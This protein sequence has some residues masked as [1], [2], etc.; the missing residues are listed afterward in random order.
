MKRVH[1]LILLAAMTLLALLLLRGSEKSTAAAAAADAPCIAIT[2]DDGPS[3]QTTAALLDG[4]K[5]RGAHTTFFLIGE[6]VAGNETL[7]R[8]MISEGHQVGSHSFTHARLDSANATVLAEIAQTEDTLRAVLGGSGYWLRPPWGFCSE[9]LKQSVSV[10]L[11]FWSLDTMDWSV[12]NADIVAQTIIDHARDGDIV[13]LHDPYETSVEAA[14][15]AIDVLSA[16]GYR[17]VTLEELFAC[18]GASAEAGHFY[19]RAGE[20]VSW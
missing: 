6:Q 9:A 19:L 3:A 11:V 17:F 16:Q 15:R 2:F 1:A 10:P 18:K 8:R 4:L 12:C 14:L 7:V 5:S 20:E 13:L